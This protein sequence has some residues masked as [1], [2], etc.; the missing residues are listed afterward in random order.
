MKKPVFILIYLLATTSLLVS[1]YSCTTQ[2]RTQSLDERAQEIYRSLMC[3]LCPGQ[4]IDQSSSE[5]S[6]QMRALVREKLEQGETREEI[7]QFFVERYGETVLATPVKSGFNLIVWL[8]PILGIFT[9][10]IVLWIIIR[11][12]VRGNIISSAEMLSP[13]SDDS[14][15]EKYYKQVKKDLEAFNERG[16]R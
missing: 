9:G 13:A 5:L 14:S 15:D 3:P 12:R 1:S 10:G 11:R 6:T 16:F 7:L 8:T 2:E 4:T